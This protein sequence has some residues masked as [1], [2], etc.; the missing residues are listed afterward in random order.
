MTDWRGGGF[1]KQRGL[2][3]YRVRGL[4]LGQE[5]RE[6]AEQGYGARA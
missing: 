1:G 2:D 4:T 5:V 6:A 3:H